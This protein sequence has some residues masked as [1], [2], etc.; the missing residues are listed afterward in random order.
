MMTQIYG[1]SLLRSDSMNKYVNWTQGEN[2]KRPKI[3]YRAEDTI[4][5]EQQNSVDVMVD[6]RV[7][8]KVCPTV[9]NVHSKERGG[10]NRQPWQGLQNVVTGVDERE[11]EPS[12]ITGEIDGPGTWI[13]VSRMT[14][15]GLLR[16]SHWSEKYEIRN[17]SLLFNGVC[18][19]YTPF[20][21]LLLLLNWRTIGT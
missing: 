3:K 16:L 14:D 19:K 18:K 13:D 12:P 20:T 17:G 1:K 7:W 9:I 2:N 4:T 8:W 15:V 10:A 5:F 6:A 11:N 21:A